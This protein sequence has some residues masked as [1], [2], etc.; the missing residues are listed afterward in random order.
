[1]SKILY[2]IFVFLLL[3]ISVIAQNYYTSVTSTGLPYHI[4]I[5][6]IKIDG[7]EV[8]AGSEI[9]IFDKTICVGAYKVTTNAQANI[10]I[11]AWK[12]DQSLGL[13]GYKDGDS[14]KIKV[15][16]NVFGVNVEKEAQ[17]VYIQGN[18]IFGSS[19]FVVANLFVS[20][21]IKPTAKV[22]IPT[23]DLG[24]VNL[25]RASSSE[26]KIY[27]TGNAQLSISNILTGNSQ[28]TVDKSNFTIKNKDSAIVKVTFTPTV[29]TL[30]ATN[31]NISSNDPDN[32]NLKLSLT[33]QGLP[34]ANS[35]ISLDKS[36]ISYG[37][38]AIGYSNSQQVRVFN[39]GG[40]DL[41]VSN[42]VSTSSAFS[43]SQKNF[44]VA[45]GQSKT[46]DVIFSPTLQQNYSGDLTI[47]CNAQNATSI[48]LS[49]SGYGYSA[50]FNPI[51]ATG[52]PYNV[53]V[54][55]VLLDN[56][57]LP[58]GSEIAL[59]DGSKCVGAGYYNGSF[60]LSIVTWQ[61]DISKALSG[62]TIGDS[63]KVLVW[64]SA[65]GVSK[66]FVPSVQYLQGNG[67][68][69][70]GTYSSLNLT[71]RTN[72]EPIITVNKINCSF[73]D[74]KIGY[75]NSDTIIIKNSGKTNL[76]LSNI[77]FSNGSFTSSVNTITVVAN[78]EY[79]L[80]VNFSPLLAKP[81]VETLS[82]STNTL[83]HDSYQIKLTGN[84]LPSDYSR[85]EIPNSVL[86]YIPTIVKDTTVQ[87]LT[88]VNSGTVDITLYNIKL[89]S[90]DFFIK[91][92][93]STLNLKAQTIL[94]LPVYFSPKSV[95]NFLGN[96]TFSSSA[97][98]MPT[99]SVNLKAESVDTVLG[100]VKVTG[101]PY[102]VIIDS[103][104][105]SGSYGKKSG[106]IIGIYDG[107]KLVGQISVNPN[108]NKQYGTAWGSTDLIN[109][110]GYLSGNNIIFK[111]YT[112]KSS[113][114]ILLYTELN[115]VSGDGKFGTG[116]YF[117]VQLKIKEKAYI[118]KT[119]NLLLPQN[120][121]K[122]IRPNQDINWS[123]SYYATNYKLIISDKSDFSTI[124]L[125]DT[126]LTTTSYN[127]SNKLAYSKTYYWRV[128]AKN[129]GGYSD[130]S[131]ANNFTMI[132]A[133]PLKIELLSPLNNSINL[134]ILNI[135]KWKK[136]NLSDKYHLQFSKDSTFTINIV[137]DTTIVDTILT[138]NN[139]ANATKYFWRVRGHNINSYG[140]WSEVNSFT[141][142]VPVPSKVLL[143]SVMN[144]AKQLEN[145]P[146]LTWKSVEYGESYRIQLSKEETFG[147]ILLD[148]SVVVGTS[149]QLT[150]LNY[151][152]SYY[153]RVRGKNIAGAG[154][155]SEVWKFGTKM[156]KPALSYPQQGG[157]NVSKESTFRWRRIDTTISKLGNYHIQV[158]KKSDFSSYVVSDS[159]MSDTLRSGVILENDTKY[160]W[161]V[162]TWN[163]ESK[164]DWSEVWSF[165]TIVPIAGM[166]KLRI[167]NNHMGRM[168]SGMRM[169]WDSVKYGEKYDIE[170][171]T[172][173]L[174]TKIVKRDT[175]L[176]KSRYIPLGLKT[177]EKY[178][179][180]VR[181][182]NVAG[183]S[184]W[185][186][187][188]DFRMMIDAATLTLPLNRAI[189]Q[190]TKVLLKWQRPSVRVL[191]KTTTNSADTTMRY[192]VLVSK[193]SLFSNVVLKDSLLTLNQREVTGLDNNTKYY[194][195]V[196]VNQ[197]YN[198]S[199]WSE[200]FNFRTIVSLPQ[201]PELLIPLNNITKLG[202][203]PAFS[204]NSNLNSMTYRLQI[205]RDSLFNMVECDDSTLI[206]PT[207][208]LTT[209]LKNGSKYYW[210]VNSKNIA[211]NSA[212][213]SIWT[214]VTEMP[215][216]KQL[217]AELGSNKRILLS[218][219]DS[220]DTEKGFYI[221][222]KLTIE[223][224]YK[225]IDS[226]K[227][228]SV[229]YIDSTVNIESE[230][231]YRIRG[232]NNVAISEYSNVVYIKAVGLER[233][234]RE[235][236]TEYSLNQNF[237]NP[238]NPTTTIRYGI[239]SESMVKIEIYNISGQ[240]VK[241]LLNENQLAGYYQKSFDASSLASGMYMYRII[242]L[243]NN[244][245]NKFVQVK[246]MI[247]LK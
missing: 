209:P 243:A 72:L 32:P 200:V 16:T 109:P 110:D 85:L 210:R 230:Y 173:S 170:I 11:T 139:L 28:Y 158:S 247:L 65:F 60:P 126:S 225:V 39:N 45:P 47:Y 236:P 156:L 166:T 224:N 241:E 113:Q 87:Q 212:W 105:Y 79:K 88:L 175:S 77:A 107:N 27:N 167:P 43:I 66:E 220:C 150:N 100:S 4:V 174:M 3:S 23:L 35:T 155:W 41:V 38:I 214:F 17:V 153:W 10:D 59:F 246:K 123:K 189:N 74:T 115:N 103:L 160:Y 202:V 141:T 31:L 29:A 179:W 22:N 6:N 54:G 121:S 207:K 21:G 69:G 181:V 51:N 95:N 176:I 172:D 68:F 188:W 127:I 135:L 70:S 196:K 133:P 73:K 201:K 161:R 222:R 14:I 137:N 50:H 90:S 56:S 205:S 233:W 213:S 124:V 120:N 62:F 12:G 211:G 244:G 218:W 140:A 15:F 83:N 132:I 199:D 197:E 136:E 245:K 204:W 131:N 63:I 165:T 94:Q 237:P 116:A 171:S 215:N 13:Q 242:A 93:G 18:N 125:V 228:N 157:T 57:P 36:S 75:S 182:L 232:Y 151:G 37:N 134:P 53:I 82:F 191:A 5:S 129:E 80:I 164:S 71:V 40:A 216:P 149:K 239:P 122:N 2:K 168:T 154:L 238:F 24:V 111:Y 25:G 152:C 34:T 194:W 44:T 138:A 61:E 193:D 178:Y 128:S 198:E 96:L 67:T 180:R 114:P 223:S 130:W 9:G 99:V 142:I 226:V 119:V 48:N 147:R 185:S 64:S 97:S 106:D 235:I 1:M 102:Q 163:S 183:K 26:F 89:S 177:G 104:I 169:E 190:P 8:T 146:L 240:L 76:V 49:V 148:D 84:G 7:I 117:S 231:F 58:I 206:L 112:K 192:R 208:Q 186:E 227:S 52:L 86:Q 118:P 101:L 55:S 219:L 30:T 144:N 20:T 33:G 108:T 145:N 19:S 162:K 234:K 217:K 221:E 46:I 143:Q 98:N 42:V 195:K 184:S 203:K 187:V 91:G 92:V 159:L 78:Q 229:A 81:Y